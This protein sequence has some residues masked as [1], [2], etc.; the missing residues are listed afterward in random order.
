[1][2][3][4]YILFLKDISMKDVSLVGGKTASLGEMY[5][6]LK[7]EG[8]PIPDG[9]AVTA[10]AYRDFLNFNKLNVPINTIL[11]TINPRHVVDLNTKSKKIRE[12]ISSG[13]MP[14]NLAKEIIRAYRKL[15]QSLKIKNLD[16]A[17]RSSATAEDLPNA[18]FAGQQESYLNIRG[19]KDLL[20]AVK[21][22]F[23]SLYTSRAISYR[24]DKK[25]KSTA[26]Y[27]S[28]VVQKMIRSDKGG[29]GII[30]TLD[31]ET[32]FKDTVVLDAVWGLG[33]MAV[34]GQVIGDEYEVFKPTFLKG[35]SSIITRKLGSKNQKMIYNP[36]KSG[37]TIKIP[38]SLKEQRQ[39]VLKD[40]EVL[41]L[42]EW[43]LK[44]EKHYSRLK[45]T[46]QPMD[47]EWAKDGITGELYIVQA[48]PETVHSQK[49]YSVIRD[50]IMGK[51][52]ELIVRGA[53]VG[54]AIAEGAARIISSPK[55]IG[56]FK[57]GE[58]L[59]TTM[60]DPDWE[61]I[62]RIAKAIITDEGGRTSHA[63]IVSRELG[64]PCIVGTTNAS[65][66]IKNG[67]RV[68]VD[69][70]SGGEG[71]VWKGKTKWQVKEYKIIPTKKLPLKLT[72]NI[73][74]PSEAFEYSFLKNDGV[75]LAREE[76]IISSGIKIHPLALINYPNLLSKSLK[77]QIDNLTL[78]YANKTDFYVDKLTEGIAK[79]G[80]AFYPK[81]V[82]LRFSDFKTNEY[83]SLIGGSLFE[84]KEENPMLGWRG[85]SRYYDPKFQPAFELEL[86]ALKKARNDMGL[87]NIYA[88]IPFCRTI[89]EAKKVV[90]I[91]KK[92]GLK[93]G[94][95]DFQLY[96]MAE[97][98]ANF[99][100]AKKF[101]EI[102]DGFS[103]G[104]NDLTQLTLGLDRDNGSLAKIGDERNE[105]VISLIKNIIKVAKQKKKY[106]GICGQAPS[107][108]PEFARLLRDLKIDSLS[109]NP[110]SLVKVAADLGKLK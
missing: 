52:G 26:V 46:W 35:F 6:H 13:S 75:G 22:C 5:S 63:A 43:A 58:I 69:C 56:L 31:T 67:Q 92:Y 77:H 109:L 89:D 72:L 95:K 84:P 27:L 12:I 93:P 103:I 110:D 49:D 53:A 7:K 23:A 81:R 20:M 60:T 3:S 88:M 36:K 45:K 30:F 11:K 15:S 47:I 51:P 24:T 9:F 66:K 74:N 100:L 38:T 106:I 91:M 1:M 59:V 37:D 102:F 97:I 96:V 98:P 82:I 83:A 80:A 10:Q 62:M 76:F 33:E 64:I 50:Y 79:I 73:G 86:Q 68:T 25:F 104:S 105:A 16:V 78:G 32:G 8:V 42:V 41:K 107:D 19:E 44:I 21:N 108:Y 34:Q 28:V 17:V 99:I 101:L 94:Q 55:Q 61:P 54:S 57:E 4:K 71:F 18:S 70:S 87:K 40:K 85:A 48:R 90:T 65:Q 14:D 29:S 39:F 2:T